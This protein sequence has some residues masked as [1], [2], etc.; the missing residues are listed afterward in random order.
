MTE[1]PESR[2]NYKHPLERMLDK[3]SKELSQFYD[4][5][6]KIR[7]GETEEFNVFGIGRRFWLFGLIPSLIPIVAVREDK[8]KKV[9]S[10]FYLDDFIEL[11]IK[12][13]RE[14][15]L[16]ENPDVPYFPIIRNPTIF[17][18]RAGFS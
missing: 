5:G 8:K 9:V 7:S 11:I 4:E 10:A 16:R 1:E 3:M 15:Y 13:Y 6:L 14:Q 2:T 12:R 17:L 18:G